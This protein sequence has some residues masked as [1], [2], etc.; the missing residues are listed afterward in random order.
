M[1]HKIKMNKKGKMKLLT[2]FLDSVFILLIKNL[3][4]SNSMKLMLG[5]KCII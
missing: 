3:K 1:I 4:L 2:I 5:G